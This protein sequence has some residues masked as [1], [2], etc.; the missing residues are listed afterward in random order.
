MSKLVVQF[1]L[2]LM[3]AVVVEVVG[4]LVCAGG[5]QCE[6]GVSKCSTCRE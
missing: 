1:W 3:V 4:V 2:S 6:C 5:D